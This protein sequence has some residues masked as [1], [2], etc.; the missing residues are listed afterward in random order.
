VIKIDN[1]DIEA[2]KALIQEVITAVPA[3]APAPVK[4]QT[5]AY[6]RTDVRVQALLQELV[7]CDVAYKEA[8]E[9]RKTAEAIASAKRARIEELLVESRKL[10]ITQAQLGEALNISRGAIH[11]RMAHARKRVRKRNTTK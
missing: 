3:L 9:T 1:L 8:L 6:V 4:T 2:L 5:R 7:E 11:S 10:K